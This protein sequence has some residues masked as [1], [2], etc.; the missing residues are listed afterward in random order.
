PSDASLMHYIASQ[1]A[2]RWIGGWT[3]DVR[4]DVAAATKRASAADALPVFVA[5]NIPHR[6]CGSYSAGG[7]SDAAGYASWIRNFA[8]GLQGR[9]VVILEPDA[10]AQ[11]S[12]LN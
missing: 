7:A 4:G 11:S 10:V 3:H 1:P 6:D 12:C 9:A 5:Y 2:A 8:A